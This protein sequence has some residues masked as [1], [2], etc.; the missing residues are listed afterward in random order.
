MKNVHMTIIIYNVAL[1]EETRNKEWHTVKRY[2][3][4]NYF[5]KRSSVYSSRRILYF[6][7]PIP[8]CSLNGLR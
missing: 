1:Q 3:R 7:N 6:I 8:P 2:C 4:F 5:V